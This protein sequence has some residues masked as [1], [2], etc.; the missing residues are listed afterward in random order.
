MQVPNF[1]KMMSDVELLDDMC[2][3]LM[4]HMGRM[5]CRDD[6]KERELA[7]YNLAF[8]SFQRYA[9]RLMIDHKRA[10]GK[11]QRPQ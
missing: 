3:V 5:A 10:D 6:I 8:E 7:D 11:K 1:K 4:V 9:K 2:G